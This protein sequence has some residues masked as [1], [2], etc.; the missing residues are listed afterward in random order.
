MRAIR[1]A[2][3]GELAAQVE[4]VVEAQGGEEFIH[5]LR[6]YVGAA[7]VI[8]P[9]SIACIRDE[10]GRLLAE[11]RSDFGGWWLPGGLIN[12]G[13]TSTGNVVREVREET[14]LEVRPTR[15]LGLYSDP[16]YCT[17][18]YPNGDQ[19]QQ[20][21]ALF[22]CEII[23]GALRPDGGETLTLDWLPPAEILAQAQ[24]ELVRITMRDLMHPRPQAYIR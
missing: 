19:V 6:R 21:G 4:P 17:T 1:H 11:R 16:S 9:G 2:Q 8:V 18:I 10:A 5:L 22:E 14:G 12:L 7:R 23:G 3:S 15:L 13:E 24:S 20:F